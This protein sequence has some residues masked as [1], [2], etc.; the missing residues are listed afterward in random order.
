M[1]REPAPF[2]IPDELVRW[3]PSNEPVVSCYVDWSVSGRGR[4]EA[5]TVIRRE[6]NERLRE[7]DPRGTPHASLRSD[8][9]H[10][11]R[12]L[13]DDA[14]RSSRAFAVFA[15]HARGL[16]HPLTFSVPVETSVHV[17]ERPVLLPLMEA[18]QDAAP[19]MVVLA[20]TNM[21]RLITLSPRGHDETEGP[22]RP[23]ATV[24]HSTEGGWG[25]LGYQRHIDTE[26]ARFAERIAAAIEETVEHEQLHH[27]VLA[28]DDV[29]LTPLKRALSSSLR[30]QLIGTHRIDIHEGIEEVAARVRPEVARIIARRR[31]AEVQVAIGQVKAGR[32][33]VGDPARVLDALLAGRVDTLV[34][35]AEGMEAAAAELMLREALAHRSRIIL[36]RGD[37]S[38]AEVG[39]AVA[40]L[41]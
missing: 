14:D 9:E 11:E 23:V 8:L 21:A 1:V 24:K 3:E 39:P 4:H 33:A 35:D 16:W 31:D 5:A 13:A 18:T 17:G 29:I 6:L 34:L 32:E 25:A 2:E 7:L 20:N 37:R 12:F 19:T 30:E 36:V 40:T 15:C 27:L 26:I 22:S 28:G 38:F 10:L 41:R